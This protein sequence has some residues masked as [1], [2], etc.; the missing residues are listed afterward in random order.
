MSRI[1]D[2]S[3]SDE[4]ALERFLP[5]RL[6]VLSNTIS[7]S[8]ARL[9][10]EQ[11][12]LSIPEWRVMAVLGRFGPLSA[13]EVRDRTAM[14]KVGVSRAVARLVRNRQVHRTTDE[15]D[16]R[17]SVL[18]LSRPGRAVHDRIVPIARQR[19]TR[20]LEVL[21]P[22]ESAQLDQLLSK[23]QARAQRLALEDTGE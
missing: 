5:Y 21:S 17:R 16:R 22:D 3:P 2:K 23:L 12:G 4:F 10:A 6:S 20:I 18:R 15:R 14:D 13:N 7:R 8:I 11:F 1:S 9:Y 19:E